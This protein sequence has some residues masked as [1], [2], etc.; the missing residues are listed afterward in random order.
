[1]TEN[2]PAQTI[3]PVKRLRSKSAMHRFVIANLALAFL[4]AP[5]P[6]ETNYV[7]AV[8]KTKRYGSMAMEKKN[9]KINVQ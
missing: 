1:M 8:A 3:A 7:S 4:V 6:D 5:D 9:A 2:A